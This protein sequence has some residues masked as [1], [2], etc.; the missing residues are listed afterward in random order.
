VCVGESE[1]AF[2]GCQLASAAKVLHARLRRLAAGFL[3]AF[4]PLRFSGTA[5]GVIE[6]PELGIKGQADLVHGLSSAA[7]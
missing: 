5:R 4:R 6:L 7:L 3:E 1:Q 2:N